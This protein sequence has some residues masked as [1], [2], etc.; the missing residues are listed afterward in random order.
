MKSLAGQLRDYAAK[1]TPAQPMV[2]VHRST[3]NAVADY[4]D[5]LPGEAESLSG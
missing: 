4:L 3:L 2:E 1:G 5:S